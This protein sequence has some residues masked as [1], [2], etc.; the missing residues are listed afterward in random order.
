[1]ILDITIKKIKSAALLTIFIVATAVSL[2]AKQP[3][4]GPVQ[5]A[6]GPGGSTYLHS[7]FYHWGKGTRHEKY[8]VF[9]PANPSVKSSGLVIM[10]HD[11]MYPDPKFY[12]GHIRHLCRRGWVVVFP[13]YQGTDQ[14]EKHYMFNIIRSVKDF[15][16]QEFS[17]QRIDIDRE[18]VAI[19]GGGCGAV[20]AVN[21]AASADYF[22]LPVP[23]AVMSIMPEA[24][25]FKLL[26][27]TG[28]SRNARMIVVSGDRIEAAGAKLSTDIFYNANRINSKNKLHVYVSSD[29][30]G[31]PPLIADRLSILSPEEDLY[32]RYI[33]ENRNTFLI[34]YKDREIAKYTRNDW[35]DSFDWFV[36]FRLFDLLLE[37]TFDKNTDLTF[38]KKNNEV[39]KM[40]YW[41][42][43]RSLKS[44]IIT[45]RP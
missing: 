13:R 23:K 42:N 37:L 9:E 24:G 12:M 11:R 17:Q 25:Y 33:V 38:I 27:L 7:S 35:I 1:M 44:L 29:Y 16:L 4:R 5:P 30:F 34:A 43:G 36:T 39:K 21:V 28:I 19:I 2:F 15:L 22:G 10:I 40:G 26:D 45:D 3:N 20:L 32:E 18:K 31:Q 14:L 41:S 8:D 6:V